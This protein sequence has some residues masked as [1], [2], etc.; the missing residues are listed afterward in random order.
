MASIVAIVNFL[1]FYIVLLSTDTQLYTAVYPWITE[2]QFTWLGDGIQADIKYI[3]VFQEKE[4]TDEYKN[5]QRLLRSL[6]SRKRLIVFH[7]AGKDLDPDREWNGFNHF[8]LVWRCE[9]KKP[10]RTQYMVSD[11]I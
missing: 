10:P 2:A 3:S 11:Y 4:E 6:A 8:H 5:G 7:E 9:A 1:L